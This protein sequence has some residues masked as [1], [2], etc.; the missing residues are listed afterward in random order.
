MPRWTYAERYSVFVGE[1]R[2]KGDVVA[3]NQRHKLLTVFGTAFNGVE[4]WSFG[5]R[6]IQTGDPE[7]VTQAQVDACATPTVT[8]WNTSNIFMPS[9]HALTG[10]KLAPIGTDGKYPPGE[11]AYIHDITPDAG[12]SSTNQHPAQCTQVVTFLAEGQPRGRASRGRIYLPCPNAAV[13]SANGTNSLGS[14]LATATATWLSAL[15]DVADL[16][17]AAIMSSL[18]TG[19]AAP[20]TQCRGDDLPDTQRRRRRQ[21]T[22]TTTTVNLT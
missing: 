6:F 15:N 4:T 3:F 22:S 10:I 12:P 17:Q 19:I 2:S 21:L 9:S 18:G 16:G 11:I 5:V 13:S 20:I 1:E 14:A 7:T 8:F